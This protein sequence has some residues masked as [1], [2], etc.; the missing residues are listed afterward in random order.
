M[1]LQVQDSVW[2][3]VS[4]VIL[5][6][7]HYHC[8]WDDDP[9][10]LQT[11]AN[12]SSWLPC[13]QRQGSCDFHCDP[14]A[15]KPTL[16][17]ERAGQFVQDSFEK[18]GWNWGSWHLWFFDHPLVQRVVEEVRGMVY[19]SGIFRVDVVELKHHIFYKS[20]CMVKQGNI[21][22]PASSPIILSS[23]CSR[24]HDLCPTCFH[25]FPD[26]STLPNFRTSA[27][28]DNLAGNGWVHVPH[29]GKC[30]HITISGRLTYNSTYMCGGESK[31]P[32]AT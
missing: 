16:W 24:L 28:R 32:L 5:L 20:S 25:A 27:P 3:T 4:D 9:Y 12:N 19:L 17:R 22:L 14:R 13:R 26:V 15:N 21:F 18:L 11:S 29:N 1:D 23:L 8:F 31:D 30:Y 2:W 10:M 7:F 6:T